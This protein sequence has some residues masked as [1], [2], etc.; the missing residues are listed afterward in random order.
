MYVMNSQFIHNICDTSNV[1]LGRG[2]PLMT[3][4][5]VKWLEEEQDRMLEYLHGF[6]FNE[7]HGYCQK[8]KR[9]KKYFAFSQFIPNYRGGVPTS[10]LVLAVEVIQHPVLFLTPLNRFMGVLQKS[11]APSSSEA[12][13]RPETTIPLMW[14]SES[15][16]NTAVVSTSI[17][18]TKDDPLSGPRPCCIP[19]RVSKKKWW[20]QQFQQLLQLFQ[21]FHEGR[22]MKFNETHGYC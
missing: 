17:S 7:T 21:L 2:R 6:F 5:L 3:D 11:F 15:V 1:L 18:G 10:C 12:P 4:F 13:T 14:T 22:E 9:K 19:S 20:F 8:K 16:S